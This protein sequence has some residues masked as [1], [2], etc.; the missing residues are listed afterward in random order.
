MEI[1]EKPNQEPSGQSSSPDQD[2]AVYEKL[3]QRVSKGLGELYDINADSIS[4][5]MDKA[6]AELREMGGY[7]KE[8]ITRALAMLKKDIAST[9]AYVKPKLDEVSEDAKNRFDSWRD[10]GGALWREMSQEGEYLMSLSRDKGGGFLASVA[11]AISDWSQNVAEKL[12]VSLTYKT[13]E[14]S[15]GGE[16]NCLDCGGKINLKQPG[17]LPPCPKCRKTEFRRA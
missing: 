1:D 10:K 5:S 11:K 13:G 15:H 3:R 17:R 8:A 14:V 7:S 2:L 12:E 6:V 16:F 9:G 4:Q